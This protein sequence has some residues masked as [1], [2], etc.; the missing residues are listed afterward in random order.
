MAKKTI[1][2]INEGISQNIGDQ[3]IQ[4]A[5][6][7][8]LKNK[9]KISHAFL[10]SARSGKA[11]TEQRGIKNKTIKNYMLT[12]K[13][14][15]QIRWF[16]FGDKKNSKS[17][18]ED[19]IKRS[20]A[21]IIGGG[22]LIKNNISL[23]CERLYLISEI[24]KEHNK[25]YG[26]LGVGV[27]EYLGGLSQTR[28]KKFLQ[29][30]NFIGVR[31]HRSRERLKEILDDGVS[32]EFSPDLAFALPR[33]MRSRSDK[34][35]IGLNILPFDLFKRSCPR[36]KHMSHFDYIS[37]WSRAACVA[38]KDFEKA[39]LFTTGSNSD[40]SDTEAVSESIRKMSGIPMHVAHPHTLSDLNGI[41]DGLSHAIVSRMHAGIIGY[42]RG[43][44]TICLNWDDK[45]LGCWE[46][47]GQRGRAFSPSLI[48]EKDGPE[49]VYLSLLHDVPAV[50]DDEF[51]L[52]IS[53]AADRCLKSFG[54]KA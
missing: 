35:G 46:S 23:F 34:A 25:P 27:D 12:P 3:A 47:A 11:Q 20:D 14:R 45:V 44:S 4:M 7:N 24:C 13:I 32:V 38:A 22:Q 5:M 40:I 6:E 43:T 51:S 42:T 37:F 28:A 49:K 10:S 15:S 19:R 26:T 29:N 8:L 31:D 48:E 16:F 18:F 17:Y 52:Q 39:I 54:L 9:F 41:F 21:V 33:R 50:T 53:E 36:Y 1:L 2:I 30:S